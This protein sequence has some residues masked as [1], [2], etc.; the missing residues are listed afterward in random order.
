M[1][2]AAKKLAGY[3]DLEWLR[4]CHRSELSA[5]PA[6]KAIDVA[7]CIVS[8]SLDMAQ[9]VVGHSPEVRDQVLRL[10]EMHAQI[11]V[12]AFKAQAIVSALQDLTPE[13][14]G[15]ICEAGSSI[16]IGLVDSLVVARKGRSCRRSA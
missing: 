5:T 10:A 3:L 4:M 7:D 16:G 13:I 11:A 15:A 9:H 2:G 6:D 1:S 14:A 8:Q 12:E